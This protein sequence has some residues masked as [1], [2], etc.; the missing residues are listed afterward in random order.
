MIHK[1]LMNES[2]YSYKKILEKTKKINY[3]NKQFYEKINI[4]FGE[5]IIDLLLRNPLDYIIRKLINVPIEAKHLNKF[6]SIDITVES[7][8]ESFSRKLP[9]TVISKN[10]FGQEIKIIFFNIKAIYIKNSYK[11][12]EKYRITGNIEYYKGQIQLV[13]PESCYNMNK[14]EGYEFV[15]PVYNLNRIKINR[16][17]FRKLIKENINVFKNI[18]FPKEWIDK[19]SIN[20]NSWESF[21]NSLI[22]LHDSKSNHI[23]EYK[24]KY[25]RRL[26]YDEILSNFLIISF[27]KRKLEYKKSDFICKKFIISNKLIKELDF[28]LT[29]GQ[30]NSYKEICNDI[31]SLNK[32]FRLIQ[33][34]VGSGKTIVALLAIANIVD[35]GFQA[36]LMAPTEILALQHYN[37]FKEYFHNF[38]I[39]IELLTG[40]NTPNEKKVIFKKLEN[41]EIDIIIGTHSLYNKNI[42]FKSLGMIVIDEQHKFGVNQ[43]LNLQNKSPNSHVLIMSATPI[44]RSLTFAVYGEIDISIIKDKPIGR[45]EIVTSII[46]NDKINEL[47]IGIKRKIN[48]NEKVFWVL[49]E[50][51]KNEI[52]QINNESIVS[53]YEYLNKI[54]YNQVDFIHGKI[55][56]EEIAKK[57]DTFK[58]GK[59]MILVS[60][61]VIEVGVDI[62]NAS[63]IVIENANKFGLAQLHQLRGRIGRGELK[64][65]CVMIHNNNLSV[66]GK[67]RLLIMKKSN[68]GFF[69]A[70]Q[71][72][73][74][75]GGGEIFGLKQT[76]LPSWR[77]FNPYFDIDLI[78]NVR[79][80]CKKLFINK[81]KYKDQINFLTTVFFRSK[82]IENYFTG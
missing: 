60:T 17:K 74:L 76:G 48:N 28:K 24:E 2:N 18:D 26:A 9:F 54:F 8:I 6:H 45:K 30:S 21:K 11:I 19:D 57:I 44:P 40:K 49:P 43:R 79:N 56:K 1:S 50:I 15:E 33:G 82:E 10:S 4:Q 72:L 69:I 23:K 39:K 42:K 55:K 3:S 58:N 80:D 38:N 46:S 32:M 67:E 47:I 70:E 75:R 52:N 34:D 5:R 61:T 65:N 68:D 14:L 37:Y 36:A 53:R 77:F 31:K 81:L 7:Y 12:G 20:N 22:N 62:P 25:R 27:L 63:I 35:S 71:D 64:S 59:T 13:H 73:N 51:G 41:H 29:K 66:N 16:K 78:D